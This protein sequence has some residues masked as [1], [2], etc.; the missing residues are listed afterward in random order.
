M[1]HWL[2]YPVKS[3]KTI[4][5]FFNEII[6]GILYLLTQ[7]IKENNQDDEYY[8]LPVD[9]YFKMSIEIGKEFGLSPVEIF[10]KWQLSELIV[11]YAD[12]HNDK[13]IKYDAE[14]K[15]NNGKSKPFIAK[16]QYIY[17]ISVDDIEESQKHEKTDA[18]KMLEKFYGN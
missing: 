12:I 3:L 5:D 14:I 8:N 11:V 7:E 13:V 15:A 17:N 9:E 18:Q 2:D 10:N 16:N 6:S 4:Q 1:I